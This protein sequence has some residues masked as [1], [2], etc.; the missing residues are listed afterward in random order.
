MHG[1]AVADRVGATASLLCALHCAALPV[2]VAALPA[3]G[4][5]FLA[6]H[7]FEAAFVG[8]AI[9]LAGTTL[10]LG[11]RR[12]RRW[13]A[14]ALLLPGVLALLAGLALH[15]QGLVH[16]AL[17]AGGGSLVA[18]GHLVNLRL[19]HGLHRH[20]PGCGHCPSEGDSRLLP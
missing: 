18:L 4:I 15:G 16:T 7:W 6:A 10:L 12:H 11:W 5:S 9:V 13:Q 8:F 17:L 3:L 19:G 2:V 14:L 20:R 1:A